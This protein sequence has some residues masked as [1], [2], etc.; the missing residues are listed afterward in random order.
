MRKQH[1]LC[2]ECF[3]EIPAR[4]DVGSSGVVMEKVCPTH[5]VQRV[6][7]ERDPQFFMEMWSQYY[8]PAIGD[9]QRD[10]THIIVTD[11]CNMEC[12]HCYAHIDNKSKDPSVDSVVELAKKVNRS[13]LVVLSGAEPTT[14]RDL[15]DVCRRI[16]DEAGKGN[17]L[18]TNAIA[19]SNYDY[20]TE[21][22]PYVAN[23]AVS[24]HT[25]EYV[26]HP[27]LWEKKERALDHIQNA[28]AE[29]FVAFTATTLGDVGGI[30]DEAIK[31]KDSAYMVKLRLGM[32]SGEQTPFLSELVETV[33][34]E[35]RKRGLSVKPYY[36]DNN[37]YHVFLNIGG[38]LF[39]L[40]RWPDVQTVLLEMLQ[41]S[42][43]A[44]W[45]DV[46]GETN[47]VYQG[48]FIE[49]EKYGKLDMKAWRERN[50]GKPLMLVNGHA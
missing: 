18:L 50:A 32:K 49:A 12:P 40:I 10:V 31:Y 7:L 11:R 17:V 39:R 24:V 47:V 1:S 23:Y 34:A 29:Y 9:P 42:P 21:L 35:A 45:I 5:G 43:F 36:L 14:R 16:I 2:G 33:V 6:M 15:P 37:L 20:F 3:D 48:L 8:D 4:I 44:R 19:L 46:L 13:D 28:G 41:T 38:Q 25:K 27:K 26:K 22:N 30:L